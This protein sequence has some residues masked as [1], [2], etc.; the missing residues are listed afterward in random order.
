MKSILKYSALIALMAIPACDSGSS[1]SA[2][3]RQAVVNKY[4]TEVW[5]LPEKKFCFVARR[6][7]GSVWYV[8]TYGG[9]ENLISAETQLFPAR[10]EKGQP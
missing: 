9:M 10:S 1:N 8:E 2:I 4:S 6:E 3:N 5:N 7:D